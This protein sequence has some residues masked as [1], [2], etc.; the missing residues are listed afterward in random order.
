MTTDGGACDDRQRLTRWLNEARRGNGEAFRH[1]CS[2]DSWQRWLIAITALLPRQLRPKVDPEDVLMETLEQA[3]RNIYDLKDVTTQG[4]HRWIPGI[5]RHRVASVIRHYKQP[6]RDVSR[7]EALPGSSWGAACR[8]D[9]T[10]SKSAARREQSAKIAAVLDELCESHR[11]VVIYRYLER[12]T[13]KEVAEMMGKSPDS[14]RVTLCRALKKVKEL[15]G[16]HG[17]ESTIFRPP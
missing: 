11:A 16:Q 7:E 14:V 5:Y 15:C 4:F 1:L 2:A 9:H 10:P 12:Y 13:G 17:I 8:D 6:K 3:W